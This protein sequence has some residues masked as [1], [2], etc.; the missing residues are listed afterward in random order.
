MSRKDVDA[1]RDF[2]VVKSD[3]DVRAQ[4]DTM[5]SICS[6][7]STT[8]QFWESGIAEARDLS[9]LLNVQ[10]NDVVL[11]VGCGMGRIASAM[12]NA[13]PQATVLG[14][15]V[16]SV[17]LQRARKTRRMGPNVRLRT[18]GS[19]WHIPLAAAFVDVAFEVLVLQHTPFA[20]LPDCVNELARVIKPGGVFGCGALTERTD[21]SEKSKKV[22]TTDSW[23][24]RAY[25]L[26][27][28]RTLFAGR[29]EFVDVHTYGP[30]RRMV[31]WKR[32]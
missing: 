1:E 25:T 13:W 7:C 10:P 8:T 3:W 11:D 26:E 16:S 23:T 32:V 17:M 12:G 6:G 20:L 29:F 28:W 22:P 19:K 4:A 18:I 14:V 5:Q 27:D 31:V 15:D 2:A 9:S 30:N 24:S 21:V